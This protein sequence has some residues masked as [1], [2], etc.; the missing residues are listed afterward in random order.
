MNKAV[1][2]FSSSGRYVEKRQMRPAG[3][4]IYFKRH[5][6]FVRKIRIPG[7]LKSKKVKLDYQEDWNVRRKRISRG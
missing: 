2:H 6:D 4:S 3:T 5:G 7:G 1:R